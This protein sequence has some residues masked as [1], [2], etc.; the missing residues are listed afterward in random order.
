MLQACICPRALLAIM[1]PCLCLHSCGETD[2]SP[3]K[4]PMLPPP[5]AQPHHGSPH[6]P[7]L[8]L[9]LGTNQ[10][11]AWVGNSTQDVSRPDDV[12]AHQ[13]R[14]PGVSPRDEHESRPV[15][16]RQPDDPTATKQACRGL[17]DLRHRAVPHHT[18]CL[19]QRHGQKGSHARFPPHHVA[20]ESLRHFHRPQRYLDLAH[21]RGCLS[22]PMD[23]FLHLDSVR[24]EDEQAASRVA[25]VHP[26]SLVST[27]QHRRVVSVLNTVS[28][29][30]ALNDSFT[31]STSFWLISATFLALIATA[32]LIVIVGFR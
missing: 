7:L 8:C 32:S 6:P 12:A 15:S 10:L 14:R 20:Q 27:T 17:Y 19:H 16:V 30:V 2:S 29:T 18:F 5:I 4:H 25:L 13:A 28:L 1:P 21:R 3:Y 26:L 22:C 11:R 31:R 24:A 23:R 9:S